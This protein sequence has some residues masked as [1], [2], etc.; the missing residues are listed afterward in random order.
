[1]LERVLNW[2]TGGR[3]VHQMN[4]TSDGA[5]V[6]AMQGHLKSYGSTQEFQCW[7]RLMLFLTKFVGHLMAHRNTRLELGGTGSGFE[8]CW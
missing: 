5:G 6:N 2:Q 4:R 1:M 3:I 7:L 8:L